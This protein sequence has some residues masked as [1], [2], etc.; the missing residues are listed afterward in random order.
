MST[1]IL[2][3]ASKSGKLDTDS[4]LRL[5]EQSLLLKIVKENKRFKINSKTKGKGNGVFRLTMEKYKQ[6][7]V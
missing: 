3:S 7:E 2:D 4:T 6:I 1:F 5:D